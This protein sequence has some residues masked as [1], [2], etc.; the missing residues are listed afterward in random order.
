LIAYSID[1]GLKRNTL[2]EYELGDDTTTC[3]VL[4]MT[5]SELQREATALSIEERRKLAAF[6][7]ALRMK[8]SGDWTEN[9]QPAGED[10]KGWVSLEDAKRRLLGGN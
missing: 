8:E 1:Q 2:R 10:R 9:P 6:L 5:L 3:H 7:A 4:V